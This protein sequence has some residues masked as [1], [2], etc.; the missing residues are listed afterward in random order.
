DLL[1]ADAVLAGYAAAAADTLFQDLVASLEH[2][3]HLFLVAF[4]EEQDRVNVAIAGVK[5]VAHAQLI[6]LADP[7]DL[8]EDVRQFRARHD[9]VLCAVARRQPADGAER[10]L[11]ALPEQV[12]LG[13]GVGL[14]DL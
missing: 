6:L 5:N 7:L 11:A 1:H 13:V 2:A 10:L 9:A 14:A 8:A 4:V 3:L 12:S